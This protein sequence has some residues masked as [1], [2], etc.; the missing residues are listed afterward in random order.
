MMG[1]SS[2][3]DTWADKLQE[4]PIADVNEAWKAMEDLLDREMPIR[5]KK[6]GRPWFLFFLVL[7]LIVVLFLYPRHSSAPPAAA[8]RSSASAI[9][10]PAESSPKAAVQPSGRPAE[11]RPDVPGEPAAAGPAAAGPAAEGES[12][13]ARS[14]SSI[15]PAVANHDRSSPGREAGSVS[16]EP[17]AIGP[18]SISTNA[19][20]GRRRAAGKEQQSSMPDSYTDRYSRQADHHSA[21]ADHYSAQADLHSA[22]ADLH[23]ARTGKPAPASRL[24]QR[25][26]PGKVRAFGISVGAITARTPLLV[27]GADSLSKAKNEKGPKKDPTPPQK[28]WEFGIGLNQSIATGGQQVWTNRS[29]GFNSPIEDYIPVPSVRYYLNPRLYLQAEARIHAPQYTRKDLEFL[30][31][32]ADSSATV[33]LIGPIPIKK[34]FYLQVPLSI[35]Y[36][37]FRNWSVGLGLQYSRFNSGL[38]YTEDTA[39]NRA[40]PI[41]DYPNVHIRSSEFRGLVS[42]DYTFKKWMLGLSYDAALTRFINYELNGPSVYAPAVQGRN[43]SLQVYLRYYFLNTLKKKKPPSP[44]K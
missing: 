41:K 25:S 36:S 18:T 42:V 8:S 2:H 31:V 35:H 30:Y 29:G 28:R 16:N 21:Q 27:P 13:S 23:S 10:P 3:N 15:K 12:A 20:K 38:T 44:A 39:G 22:Q 32:I 1:M 43:N 9:H 37:P 5:R 11:P 34:L 24:L 17:A 40:E 26:E 14:A 4:I 6:N 7:L 19:A 33:H